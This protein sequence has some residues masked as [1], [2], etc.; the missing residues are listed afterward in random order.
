MSYIEAAL[1]GIVQALTEFLPVSS[2]GH[3]VLAEKW[4]GQAA[5]VDVFFNVLL[6][7]ATTTA[8]IV[9]F[10]REIV[11]L[12]AAVVGRHVEPIAPFVGQ[13]RRVVWFIVL[14]SLPT[15]LIGLAI[16]RYLEGPMTHPVFVGMMLL[17]TGVLLWIGRT[18]VGQ[19]GAEQMLARDALLIGVVQGVAV[20]PGI[21]RAGATIVVAL[22]LGLR[23][24]LAAR[25]SLLIS[26]PAVV[27]ATMVEA[28]GIESFAQLALGPYVLGMLLAACV[29]YW[30]IH[31]IL[32]LVDRRLFYRFAFYVWPLGTI[33]ILSGL[34]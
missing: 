23:R 20:F 21:S 22:L 26:I 11:A 1:L 8:V 14:A 30:S 25:F 33:A 5:D 28:L 12:V 32:A 4:F 2:S 6:H 16:E 15:A 9:Y 27:G 13:E 19:R 7:V 3:L 34:R 24:D 29:G 18:S 10:R 31:V 17:V